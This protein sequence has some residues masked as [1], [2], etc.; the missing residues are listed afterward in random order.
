MDYGAIRATHE[1]SPSGLGPPGECRGYAALSDRL[2]RNQEQRW[3]H[4][5]QFAETIKEDRDER[6]I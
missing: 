6:A 4:L 2:T 5:I 1:P 3:S